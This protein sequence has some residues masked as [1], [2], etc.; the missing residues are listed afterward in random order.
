MIVI[1]L[2]SSRIE[3]KKI[4]SF[5]KDD[6]NI[7]VNYESDIEKFSWN[8]SENII[9]KRIETLEKNIYNNTNSSK[10]SFKV[11][12]EVCFY[13]LP[14]LE[15]LINNFPYLKFICT[16]KSRQKTYDDIMADITNENNFLL[17]LFLFRKK[18][19][20]HFINHDGKK[21]QKDYILDKCYPKFKLESL[22]KS[23]EEYIDL[24]YSNVKSIEK[25]YP[26]NLK[27]F[28]SDELQSKYGKKK[29]F[30]FI[31]MK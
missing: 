20:N 6:E 23:I 7:Y 25:K 1:G 27:V 17:R 26:N 21:W 29:I 10:K 13:I 31:G 19:K 16:T 24:Y 18:F 9:L 3:S 28:Y 14:Y 2:S 4:F 22:E 12:G 5:L 15:I 11:F 8:N 30:S